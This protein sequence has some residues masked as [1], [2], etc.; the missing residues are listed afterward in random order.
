[1]KYVGSM[2]AKTVTGISAASLTGTV[3]STTGIDCKG[4]DEALIIWNIGTIA[5]T[6][7]QTVNIQE[8]GT[9]AAASFA[10]V[11]G[12]CFGEH[13][14]ATDLETYVGTINLRKR[15]RYIRVRSVTSAATAV[16]AGVNVVLLGAASMPA[17]QENTNAFRV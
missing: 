7:D 12:A 3:T 17:T 14:A 6:A 13:L 16:V 5:A 2:F 8:A 9:N 10:N 1:M 11:T 15:K 4:F